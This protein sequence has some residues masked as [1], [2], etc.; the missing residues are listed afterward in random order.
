MADLFDPPTDWERAFDL[1]LEVFTLQ[2][3]LPEDQDRA[4]RAVA[5][6]VAPGGELVVVTLVRDPAIEPDGPPWP[7][8]PGT[9]D[10]LA[11]AGLAVLGGED[12]ELSPEVTCMRRV[13]RREP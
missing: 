1:V 3:I 13:L 10:E 6:L 5:G 7:L 11:V 2:S 8:H 12:V 9:L 4:A